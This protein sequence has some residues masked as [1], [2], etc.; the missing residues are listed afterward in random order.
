MKSGGSASRTGCRK[1]QIRRLPTPAFWGT[2]EVLCW[3]CWT[4]RGTPLFPEDRPPLTEQ[5]APNQFRVTPAQHTAGGI[6]AIGDSIVLQGISSLPRPFDWENPPR[7]DEFVSSL[8]IYRVDGEHLAT[9][10]LPQ[11]VVIAFLDADQKTGRVFL[12]T[13]EPG[14]QAIEYGL[15][16]CESS[17]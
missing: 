9:L 17:R 12:P 6:A 16:E 8:G 13:R 10:P 7:R 1:H 4:R 15:T 5:T 2:Y 14:P 11:G 3:G